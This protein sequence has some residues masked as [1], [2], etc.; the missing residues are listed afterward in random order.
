MKKEHREKERAKKIKELQAEDNAFEG[1][2]TDKKEGK[3]E[4]KDDKQ[5]F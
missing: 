1:E 3:D 2:V 5:R 4:D